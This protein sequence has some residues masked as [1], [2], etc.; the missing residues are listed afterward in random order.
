MKISEK[1]SGKVKRDSSAGVF[2]LFFISWDLSFI[3][4]NYINREDVGPS[5]LISV[6]DEPYF[7]SVG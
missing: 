4:K 7:V 3:D 2:V 5:L 1:T 6:R